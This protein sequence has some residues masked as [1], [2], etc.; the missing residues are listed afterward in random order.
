MR[1][2]LRLAITVLAAGLTL[3]PAIALAQSVPDA[4]TNTPAT[5]AIGPRD[6]QN[7]SLPGTR[8]RP[9]GQPPAP[10]TT[11]Q[12]PAR[13]PP[14]TQAPAVAEP[15]TTSPV[16]SD[17]AQ[18]APVETASTS[19]TPSQE[20]ARTPRPASQPLRQTAPSSS[21][22]VALP[23]LDS[24]SASGSATA[25]PAAAPGFAPAPESAP[26]NLA[27][28]QGVP[29]LPW[30]LA[31]LALAAGAAFLFWRNRS[32][33]AFAGGP[34]IAAFTAPEPAPAPAPP[35]AARPAPAPAPR[36]ARPTV[37]G[38]VVSTRLR[39]W[40]D[41]SMKPLRCIVEEERVRIEF[42]L[43]LFN[44]G[45]APARAVLVEATLFNAG[46]TQDK[47]I[48]AFFAKP[49]GEGNRIATIAPFKRMTLRTQ[50]AAEREHVRVLQAG[51]RMVFVPLIA[52]NALYGWSGGEG[53]TSV[54]YLLGRD[55]KGEKMAPFRIDLGPRVFRGVGARLLPIGVR[56]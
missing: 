44:S 21:V 53:Q 24:V 11:Q 38:G 39:P 2:G 41:V 31:A 47:E 5:D 20:P 45:N 22:T 23:D 46:P 50:V 40:L 17:R 43:D 28:G 54:S 6:L 14:T 25:L 34:Q 18:V 51:E 55:T 30:L 33:E 35:P 7:F 19:R 27:P 29:V 16:R 36:K 13:T 15:R 49:V 42:E 8:N 4:A 32:R 9:A 26:A 48:G 10:G 52:F 56:N 37:P 12:P 1:G 3:A